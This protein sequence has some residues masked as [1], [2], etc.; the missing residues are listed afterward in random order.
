MKT[1]AG[2]LKNIGAWNG[3]HRVLAVKDGTVEFFFA[4]YKLTVARTG[5]V[6]WWGPKRV[7]HW[8]ALHGFGMFVLLKLTVHPPP[9]Y[10]V[11]R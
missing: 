10:I 1:S 6:W 2:V 3:I 5:D 11:P 7:P 4:H 8:C 9:L